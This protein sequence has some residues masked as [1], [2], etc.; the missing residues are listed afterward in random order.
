MSENALDPYRLETLASAERPFDDAAEELVREYDVRWCDVTLSADIIAIT[1]GNLVYILSSDC[2]SQVAT[3][4]HD[5]RVLTTALSCDSSFVAFGDDAGMLFI[6]H[7]ETR[8]PVF[9]QAIKAPDSRGPGKSKTQ[10]PFAISALRF[11]SPTPAA[12]VGVREELVLTT[13]NDTMVRFSGIQLSLLSKAIV[14]GNMELGARIKDEIRVEFVTLVAS[15]RSIHQSGVNGLSLFHSHDRS[16]IVV[17]GDGDAC[18]SCWERAENSGASEALPSTSLVDIVT[19]DCAGSGYIK[20]LLSLDHRYIV[21]LSEHGALDVYECSTLTLVFRYSE[22]EIDDFSLLAPGSSNSKSSPQT[23][24][25]V[26]LITKPV[27]LSDD[28]ASDGEYP[29]DES[30]CRRLLVVS[31]PTAEVIYSMDVSEWSWL[32]HDARSSQDIADSILFVE[33]TARDG[34]QCFFLRSLNE[35]V[36]LERL[37]HFLRAGR[38]PEAETFAENCNIPLSLVYR[39][40]IEEVLNG[41]PLCI[42]TGGG[43]ADNEQHVYVDKALDLLGHIDDVDFVVESCIRMPCPSY[44]GTHRLL[45]YS[46]SLAAESAPASVPRILNTIQRLGTWSMVS[47]QRNTVCQ[48]DDFFDLDAW[49]AFRTADLA[50]YLRSYIAQG[51]I[52]GVS[53]LWRR[54]HE[55]GRLSGGISSAVQGFSMD[56]DTHSLACWLRT[57]VLPMLGA[58]QQ[59]HEIAVWIEQRARAL[60]SKR[61]RI[62]DALLLANLLDIGTWSADFGTSSRSD[63]AS[64]GSS[65]N[66]RVC[67]PV[68]GPFAITPQNFI[69]NSIYTAKW[70]VELARVSGVSVFSAQ[71]DSSTLA[72]SDAALQSCLFLR[73]QLLD[74]VYLRDKHTMVL[75]LEE[76]EQLSYSAIATELLDRVGAPELLDE[77]YFA[78]FVPYSEHHQIDFAQTLREYCIEMMDA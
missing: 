53:A 11:S 46:R 67:S 74:L 71:A 29:A 65:L 43:Q 69:E 34:V 59:W 64:V 6:V 25:L 57:E 5:T 10:I 21:A 62:A 52:L 32:A 27:L 14:D 26:A 3:I 61:N 78:H 38:Y 41:D 58:R 16:H 55:D 76:F 37:T 24:I 7:I 18:M 12:G 9:S 15:K 49:H 77:A 4:R 13:T 30:L 73:K 35:T 51:D 39:K 70:T 56:I 8:K 68:C 47:N 33:G 50:S 60:A 72:S 23:S 66:D 22:V 28:D 42:G 54:H 44:A 36:P 45:E 19:A 31:L 40:R 1:A 75:T 2:R 48:G 17:A 63:S 20:I